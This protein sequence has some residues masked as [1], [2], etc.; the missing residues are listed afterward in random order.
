MYREGAVIGNWDSVERVV[1]TELTSHRTIISLSTLQSLQ[2]WT[3]QSD[4]TEHIARR[5]DDTS[6]TSVCSSVMLVDCGHTVQR[7]VKIGT[8]QDRSVSWLTA[9]GVNPYRI[10]LWSGIR[11]RKISAVWKMARMSRY[12]SMCWAS[13]LWMSSKS[14]AST[15]IHQIYCRPRSDDV[16][17]W[18]LH[19]LLLDD[20]ME[21]TELRLANILF[22][23]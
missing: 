23:R 2:S 8:W 22:S 11:P 17:R 4:Y 21:S 5:D 20:C 13:C 7:K 14:D 3:S 6:M 12:L 18:N 10:I 15:I 9:R 16:Q 1:Y 19:K